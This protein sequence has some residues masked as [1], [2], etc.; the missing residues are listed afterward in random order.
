MKRWLRKHWETA[1]VVAVLL[2]YFG[3]TFVFPMKCPVLWLTG[4]SCPGCGIT[5]GLLAIC[6]LDFAAAWRY[7]P[8]SFYLPVILPVLAVCHFRK[9]QKAVNTL[10][11]ISAGLLILVYLCRLPVWS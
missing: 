3:A 2:L 5:R 1:V 4:I 9:A 6:R 10:L 7:N 11:W 8:M